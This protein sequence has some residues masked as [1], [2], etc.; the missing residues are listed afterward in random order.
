[1]IPAGA[2]RKTLTGQ[3]ENSGLAFT[4][5][6]ILRNTISFQ[7][8]ISPVFWEPSGDPKSQS[9]SVAERQT[10]GA[11][12]INTPPG[13]KQVP[14]NIHIPPCQPQPASPQAASRQREPGGLGPSGGL[15]PPGPSRGAA[16]CA[17]PS[18]RASCRAPRGATTQAQQPGSSHGR[19]KRRCRTLSILQAARAALTHPVLISAAR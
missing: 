4:D 14:A 10:L 8:A 17:N 9:I 2:R 13:A 6:P 3:P 15:G 18:L 11:P 16:G 19:L 5:T 1:M 12:E 7:F